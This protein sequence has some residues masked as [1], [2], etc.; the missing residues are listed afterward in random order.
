M[1]ANSTRV[2]TLEDAESAVALLRASITELCVA[3]HGNDV[4]ILGE[5]LANK[6][7]EQWQRWVADRTRCTLVAERGGA[8]A[9]VGALTRGGAIEL[10]YVRPGMQGRGV[11]V[12]LLFALEA[13]AA[14]WG[15]KYLSL[16]STSS[17]RTFYERNGYMTAREAATPCGILRC[18][19]YAK[20]LTP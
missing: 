1:P 4:A 18:F 13:W 3:D 10:C 2:A 20:Q 16:N 19:P 6:T 12:A 9:G 15:L 8:L 7:V 11:G 14:T 5:W 17:A